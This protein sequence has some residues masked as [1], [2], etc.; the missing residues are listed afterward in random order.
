MPA[1]IV[2]FLFVCSYVGLRILNY[3]RVKKFSC[4]AK[5]IFYCLPLQENSRKLLKANGPFILYPW[6][7]YIFRHKFSSA[8]QITW[9]AFECT[10]LKCLLFSSAKLNPITLDMILIHVTTYG[11]ILFLYL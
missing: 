7:H 5:L 4:V 8:C 11:I 6:T 3:S 1:P 9:K 2:Y 10:C